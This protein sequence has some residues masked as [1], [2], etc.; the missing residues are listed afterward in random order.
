MTTY[1]KMELEKEARNLFKEARKENGKIWYKGW[2]ITVGNDNP[3]LAVHFL[4]EN[5]LTKT[6][7][8]AI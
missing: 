5:G 3:Y 6:R 4:M 8:E 1:S 2:S 7:N